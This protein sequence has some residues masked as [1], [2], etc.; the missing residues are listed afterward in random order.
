[1]KISFKNVFVLLIAAM[2]LTVLTGCTNWHKKHDALNV[3][4]QNLNGRFENCLGSLET[5]ASEQQKLGSQLAQSQMT[6]E[7]LEQAIADGQATTD[8]TGFTGMDVSIDSAAGTITVTLPNT[9]LFTAGKATLK[10]STIQELD[11]IRS[12]LRERYGNLPIDIVGH[13]DSD[14]IKKS[15]WKDNWQ[16][17]AERALA[18]LRY[19]N[20]Q[21]I[22]DEQIRAVAAGSSLPVASNSNAS[23]KSK[24]RRVEIV[25]HTR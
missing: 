8:D 1:M 17:S 2:M 11:H 5:S 10:K 16:L 4:Y 20:R 12:V 23:G 22:R 13:T 21:G 6:I 24:N 7:E 19:L 3:E 25:V 18:V 9:L 15:K 14:P